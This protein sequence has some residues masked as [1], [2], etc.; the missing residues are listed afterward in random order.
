MSLWSF[1][2]S[3]VGGIDAGTKMKREPIGVGDGIVKTFSL[4]KTPIGA[5]TLFLDGG[6]Y[7]GAY[8][9]D[10]ELKTVTF[11]EA[12]YDQA[13]ITALYTVAI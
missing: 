2:N 10:A 13:K 6:E 11:D 9:Q 3:G 12:P 7:E 4:E 8:S 5:V 1:I